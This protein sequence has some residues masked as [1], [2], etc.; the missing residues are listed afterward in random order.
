MDKQGTGAGKR[1]QY[2]E[3]GGNGNGWGGASRFIRGLKTGEGRGHRARLGCGHAN[4]SGRPTNS[5]K[6]VKDG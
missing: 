5:E 6:G 3:D 1:P 4:G 2:S